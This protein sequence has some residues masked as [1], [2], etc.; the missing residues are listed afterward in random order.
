MCAGG[1][2]PKL[3]HR[4]VFFDKDQVQNGWLGGRGRRFCSPSPQSLPA[5]LYHSQQWRQRFT[6]VITTYAV[7]QQTVMAAEIGTHSGLLGESPLW[8]TSDTLQSV[9]PSHHQLSTIM[10]T[11][12]GLYFVSNCSSS[13]VARPQHL[14]TVTILAKINYL[15]NK[16][17]LCIHDICESH[18]AQDKGTDDKTQ[19]VPAIME[20]TFQLSQ[21]SSYHMQRNFHIIVSSTS[22]QC[23]VQ[24]PMSSE[25]EFLL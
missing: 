24:N 18:C 7:N 13:F 3:T 15:I 9:F 6:N 11:T 19:M 4:S 16:Q 17:L 12:V 1:V 25:V 20:L 21:N 23:I 5:T 22:H 14:K 8:L 10:L 2:G